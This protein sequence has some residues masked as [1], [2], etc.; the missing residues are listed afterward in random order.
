MPIHADGRKD[1]TNDREKLDHLNQ[2]W[3]VEYSKKCPKCK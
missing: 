1:V 3:L 2:L